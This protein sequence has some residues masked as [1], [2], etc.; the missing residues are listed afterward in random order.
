MS[1]DLS[2]SASLVSDQ[3]FRARVAAAL[4]EWAVTASQDT[5]GGF[6][7]LSLRLRLVRAVV[8]DANRLTPIFVAL[9]ADDA[10]ISGAGT[11]ATDEDIRR[12]VD[13]MWQPVAASVPGI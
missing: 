8:Y 1:A 7:V 12:V 11:A 9:C 13:A 6:D 2:N 3:A 4:T 10:T 5:S